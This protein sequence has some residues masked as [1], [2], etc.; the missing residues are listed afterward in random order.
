MR[1][2]SARFYLSNISANIPQMHYRWFWAYLLFAGAVACT[3][4]Y[5]LIATVILFF[6]ATTT[7]VTNI[8][9]TKHMLFL[10][11]FLL[12]LCLW[13]T[14]GAH[15]PLSVLFLVPIA[16]SAITLSSRWTWILALTSSAL[17]AL[18]FFFFRDF[19]VFTSH[20]YHVTQ[21][22]PFAF[23]LWGMLL[24]FG[25]VALFLAFFFTKLS[26]E[27]SRQ[28]KKFGILTE[29][30]ES[31]KRTLSITSLAASTA[32]EINTPLATIKLIASELP[33]SDDKDLLLSE[34]N[35]CEEAINRL[36]ISLGDLQ[37]SNVSKIRLSDLVNDLRD[38]L[39]DSSRVK[40]RNDGH[41]TSQI[42]PLREALFA[43]IK[44]ALDANNDGD[45]CVE[46]A[47]DGAIEI[48]DSGSGISDEILSQIGLP[49]TSE[50][51][52]GLGL[53]LSK[54]FVEMIGGSLEFLRNNG[55]I[56]RIKLT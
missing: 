48:K 14:G 7:A 10:D 15:N 6:A 32:H 51:G 41:V 21:S 5:D 38:R 31:L 49:I 37:G 53:F 16:V 20:Y 33:K 19:P 52:L 24:G 22:S 17:F 18:L 8:F 30:S 29:R 28:Q 36:R 34:V 25:L 9:Y 13:A 26:G 44:N 47:G 27:V 11:I 56:V 3:F 54:R 39:P 12:T 2:A 1:G 50:K 55:T 46:I 23:H 35:R 42:L 43:I 40:V 4:S 45:V